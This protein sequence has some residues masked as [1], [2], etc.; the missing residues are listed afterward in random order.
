M[1]YIT[2]IRDQYNA[3]VLS[4]YE[5]FGIEENA[6]S[7]K[8]RKAFFAMSLKTHPDRIKQNDK[9]E[10]NLKIINDAFAAVSNMNEILSDPEKRGIYD[11]GLRTKRSQNREGPRQDPSRPDPP[12][13]SNPNATE[14]GQENNR[15][16]NTS[17]Q[18]TPGDD[19]RYT[20]AGYT[21][22]SNYDKLNKL[23]SDYN[24]ICAKLKKN[25]FYAETY[26]SQYFEISVKYHMQIKQ[27]IFDALENAKHN[28]FESESEYLNRIKKLTH[29]METYSNESE[30]QLKKDAEERDLKREQDKKRRDNQE[31]PEYDR[32]RDKKEGDDK[33]PQN[34][35]KCRT[36][37]AE[38]TE[39]ETNL[40]SL[41]SQ[42]HKKKTELERETMQILK[43]I[44][45][46]ITQSRQKIDAFKSKMRTE[47]KAF[48][49]EKYDIDSDTSTWT[50]NCR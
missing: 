36:L 42:Y 4:Y 8:I 34:Q 33:E 41:N 30:E 19:Y 22:A 50:W 44:K 49:S 5:I 21:N 1:T 18:E 43:E 37:M 16:Q 27:I 23:K 38:L 2:K 29:I 7:T 10:T 47:N 28:I 31:H 15:N 25:T 13:T 39:L 17:N 20:Y 26:Q 14:D 40:A 9:N 11:D 46:N 3:G 35:A 12:R 24:N 6:S 32:G 48:F 45:N